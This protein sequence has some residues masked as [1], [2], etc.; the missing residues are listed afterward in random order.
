MNA[1]RRAR[2]VKVSADG[3][4]VVSRSGVV[5]LR[6]LADESGLT[7]GWTE[8][9]LDTYRAAPVVHAPGAVLRDL[10]VTIADGGDALAH[11]AALRDQGKLFGT[12]ASDSTAWR[13]VQRVDPEH[14]NQLRAARAAARARVWSAGGG[15]RLFPGGS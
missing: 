14:L 15:P 11:L 4:G 5:L 9:L 7:A 13:V 1:S 6:E 10:A 8:A 12:V 3:R 2:R